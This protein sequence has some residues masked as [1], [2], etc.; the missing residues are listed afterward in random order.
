MC[1]VRVSY[2][3]YWQTT[4]LMLRGHACNLHHHCSMG[5]I[6]IHEVWIHQWCV[7][8]RHYPFPL[9]YCLL[10]W[11]MPWET[12]VCKPGADASVHIQLIIG[13]AFLSY[14]LWV[15]F[16]ASHMILSFSIASY[17][18]PFSFPL[19]RLAHEPALQEYRSWWWCNRRL[20]TIDSFFLSF[21]DFHS[22]RY[23]YILIALSFIFFLSLRSFLILSSVTSVQSYC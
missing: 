6:I 2:Y 9:S 14:P 23:D 21:L 11:E 8:S 16:V 22:S 1:C 10:S 4:M 5:E 17:Y 7:Q 20:S 15:L 12:P 13:N 18:F 3:R 19:Y